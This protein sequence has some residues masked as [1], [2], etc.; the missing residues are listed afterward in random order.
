MFEIKKNV[1][2]LDYVSIKI[3]VD[4]SKQLNCIFDSELSD[5]VSLA[6]PISFSEIKC[7]GD[8]KL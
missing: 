6:Y 8:K 2:F 1:S 4:V 7:A 3:C 5:F